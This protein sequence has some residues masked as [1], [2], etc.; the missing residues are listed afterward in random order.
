MAKTAG[1]QYFVIQAHGLYSFTDIGI[2]MWQ[3]LINSDVFSEKNMCTCVWAQ[4][5]SNEAM[6]YGS[7]FHLWFY[8]TLRLLIGLL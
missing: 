3:Y 4:Y 1:M 6:N 2:N 7:S 5:M 8:Y